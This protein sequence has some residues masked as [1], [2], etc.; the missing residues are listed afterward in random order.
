SYLAEG[1]ARKAE[2]AELCLA[3]MEAL[4]PVP[5]F[6]GK[7]IGPGALIELRLN[8]HRDWYFLAPGGGGLEIEIEEEECVIITPASPIGALLLGKRQGAVFSLNG[9]SAEILQAL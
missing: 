3:R 1:Q 9:R 8:G 6:S 4:R 5:D 2:E 7:A